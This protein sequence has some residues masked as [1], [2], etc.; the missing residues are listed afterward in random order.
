MSRD[1]FPLATGLSKVIDP[2]IDALRDGQPTELLDQVTDVTSELLKF[3]FQQDYCDVRVLNFHEGQRAAIL[4]TIYAH[5]VLGTKRL[6][7]L[8][9]AV[10]PDAM[11][12]GQTLS[13]VTRSVHDHPKY[14]AK[15]ATGTGKTWVLNALLLWQYLNKIADPSDERFTSNFLIVAPGLVVYDRLLD[16]FLGKERDGERH[17]ESSDIFS[18]QDLFVPDN[19]TDTV[20]G[21]L[22]SSVVT[23]ADIGRK[24]TG[25]GLI[26]VTNWHLLAG[27]EDPDFVPDTEAPGVDLDPVAA[28]ESMFPLT[29]GTATGNSLEV[30][31]RRFLRGGPLAALVDLPD[32][33]VFN[34]EAHHIHEIKRSGEVTEVEWQRSLTE[35]ASTKDHRFI[36]VDFSATPY[37]QVGSGKNSRRQYFPHI[38][39]DFDLNQAMTAGLVKALALDKRKEVAAL[40]L[41]FKAERDE[42]KQVVGLSNGQRVMLRAGLTKL[43]ILEEHFAKTDPTQHPKLLVVCEET[44]VTPHVEDFLKMTGLSDEDILAVDSNRKGEMPKKEWERVR[45][46]LFDIDRH[47]QPKVIVSVLML[48]E[49]FDVNN[50]C[51]IVPLRSSQAQILLEQTIGRGLRLMWRGDEQIDE[52]KRETRERFRQKLEPSN[53]FDVLFIV[54]HPAFAQFYEDLLSG[55]LAGEVGDGGDNANPS[56]DLISVDLREGYEQFDIS[57]PLVIRD[58]EEEL[59]APSLDPLSLPP[60]SYELSTLKRMVGRGDRFV[61]EDAQTGTQY[62]DYRVDGGVMTAVGYN[63][64]LSRMTTRIAE[65]LSGRLTRS[66]KQYSDI[67]RFPFLQAYRPML[68]GWLDTYIRRRMFDGDFYPLD[69]ENWR[70]LL[71]PDVVNRIAAAFATALVDTTMNES[72]DGAEVLYRSFSEVKTISVR[73][74]SAVDVTKC[75]YATLPIPTKA[76]GLERTF[77]QWADNDSK[78]EALIKVHEYRHHFMRRPYLKADGMP[79]S[80]SPDFVV[81][82]AK[83]V[84]IV[85][86]KAQTALSDENVARKQRAA[87]S[88]VEQISSLQD[89]QR[90]NRTWHYVL[91]GERNVYDWKNNGSQATDLLEYARIRPSARPEQQRFGLT[92]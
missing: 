42:Q 77:I 11:L 78:V 84:Y 51:V 37:N 65:A 85:E 87:L 1:L 72:V 57:I 6:R 32:L 60:Y 10:A 19:Y 67:S 38:I 71:I 49:G 20:F 89:D 47:R 88:W 74:H 28:V 69:D 29:P 75:I 4:N 2:Q 86:T 40:P 81:R 62:G 14:A 41:D 66:A 31:D 36:Q 48:R 43:T 33:C 56:G 45:E 90:L 68:T 23:K 5:E 80:Y 58:E 21:F 30:L 61:S 17:F 8:Y 16:S 91:L 79:G 70:V 25:S 55:G 15:M 73:K 50:I 64:Y 3:W 46:R 26:A 18:T 27:E 59:R 52:L 82:T 7:D 76:G 63:D 24:V 53:Y 92:S 83:A 44:S 9:E 22:Q 35:I 39:V 34:D 12:E 54:E 13:E